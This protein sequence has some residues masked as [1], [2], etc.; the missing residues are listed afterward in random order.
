MKPPKSENALRRFSAE[1]DRYMQI[2]PSPATTDKNVVRGL[3]PKNPHD[4]E[5]GLAKGGKVTRPVGGK[6]GKEDGLVAV[7]KGEHVIKKSSARKYGDKKMAAVNKGT[8][9]VTT[10]GGKR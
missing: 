2:D 10:K 6:R 5:Q 4:N 3:P 8:A 9:K 7:Q 1:T